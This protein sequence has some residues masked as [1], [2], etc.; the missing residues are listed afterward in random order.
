MSRPGGSY[1][2]HVNQTGLYY[3]YI[4]FRNED[5]LK[6]SALYWNKV[7]RIVPDG[8]M[9]HD[10]ETVSVLA[11]ELGLVKDL[12]PLDDAYRV[13]NE[14][15]RALHE[16]GDAQLARFNV[17]NAS[18]WPKDRNTVLSHVPQN[19][20]Q[21]A[22]VHVAKIAPDVQHELISRGLAER[23]EPRRREEWLG[24]H[25]TLANAYM[26]ALA[27][28]MASHRGL[29]LLADNPVFHLAANNMTMERRLGGMLKIVAK[30]DAASA[31][32]LEMLVV[33]VAFDAVVPE[34]MSRVDARTIVRLRRK[35]G[36]EL[37][38]Y[39]A[40][41]G[42]FATASAEVLRDVGDIEYRLEHLQGL[43]E[44]HLGQPGKEVAKILRSEGVSKALTTGEIVVSTMSPIAGFALG[45]VGGAVL[46]AAGALGVSVASAF[47]GRAQLRSASENPT[48]YLLRVRKA[49]NARSIL[50]RVSEE[51]ASYVAARPNG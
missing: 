33:S 12:D 16:F 9:L 37:L 43:Y 30:R 42:K 27:A 14:F 23:G 8:Y 47:V 13:Q 31:A 10:S 51:A 19:R 40:A 18:S 46:A 15:F 49:L 25:P 21:L 35:Y 24:M 20:P 7:A 11:G 48:A 22:Y 29:S 28:E 45:G 38:S 50:R 17:G 1:H 6:V 39:Q 34:D 32:E 4:H 3:P 26:S 44:R 5:W 36:A 41:V 2:G